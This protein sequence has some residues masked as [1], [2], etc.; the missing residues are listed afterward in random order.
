MYICES[1]KSCFINLCRTIKS[2][3]YFRI[4]WGWSWLWIK[5]FAY[6]LF[7]LTNSR[8]SGDG[9]KRMR[10]ASRNDKFPFLLQH[11]S[12]LIFFCFL[13]WCRKLP[14]IHHFEFFSIAFFYLLYS[15]QFFIIY[16]EEKVMDLVPD[17]ERAIG[18]PLIHIYIQREL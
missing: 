1:R 18:L 2:D 9:R 4:V 16:N 11:N 17:S 10:K 14:F 12:L 5:L 3:S 13:L 7:T 8:I 6:F 15:L